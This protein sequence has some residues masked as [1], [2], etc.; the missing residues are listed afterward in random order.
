MPLSLDDDPLPESLLL[1]LSFNYT[2]VALFFAVLLLLLLSAIIS[3]SEVALFS[4]SPEQRAFIEESKRK[5]HVKILQL[6]QA[7]KKLLATILIAN[8]LVNIGIVVLSTYL[9]QPF[10]AAA[11]S[12]VMLFFLEVV[13][14]TL[15]ILIFGEIIPKVYA[16]RAP[17]KVSE[18]VA[19][20]IFSISRMFSWVS[21]LLV[22]STNLVEQRFQSSKKLSVDE[23]SKAVELTSDALD[24]HE[25]KKILEG[26]VAFGNTEVSE[27]MKPRVQVWAVDFKTEFDAL[28]DQI[29][30]KGYSRIPIY[31]ESLDQ[32]KGVL[33]VKDLIHEIGKKK[34][35]WQK[36]V[37][38]PFF[39]PENKKIDDLLREFQE[40]RIH[41]AIVV[42]EYGGT[43]G[44][45]TLEDIIEE[46][47][48]EIT[49]EFDE[50]QVMY[51][52][53]DA[54][55]YVFQGGTLLKD[56]YKILEIDG[57]VFDQSKGEA[58]TLAGFLLE[59]MGRIPLKGEKLN[60]EAYQFIVESSDK[61]KVKSIKV[62]LPQ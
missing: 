47:V 59:Q 28:V 5:A 40:K 53:L 16:N 57:E 43:S 31:E 44:I 52:K 50:D 22:R 2:Q 35:K 19:N 20:F 45:V 27:I 60:F 29:L 49:D 36:L 17:L 46:I 6:I 56:M 32:I 38:V 14:I 21:T 8:N 55:N 15:L 61:R 41:M 23:L 42:D 26:I 30:D 58:E 10:L 3:G 33:Y 1:F 18:R 37:R 4:I 54:Q 11:T 24:S 25:E 39:V 13:V 51:S 34:V 9:L 12:K 48:G 7:P 62:T